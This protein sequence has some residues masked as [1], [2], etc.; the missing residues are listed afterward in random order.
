MADT[1][2]PRMIMVGSHR[3]G[4]GKTMLSVLLATALA[5]LD[6]SVM[7]VDYSLGAGASSLEHPSMAGDGKP[8]TN[9]TDK[10]AP[11]KH[12]QRPLRIL[13]APGML[14]HNDTQAELLRY[15][16]EQGIDIVI[17]DT[18]TGSGSE[19][20]AILRHATLALLVV[21]CEAN[22]FRTLL[23]LMEYIQ[24]ERSRPRRDF[25]TRAVLMEPH[26]GGFEQAQLREQL[27][28]YLAAIHLKPALPHDAALG[29]QVADGIYPSQPG[30]EMTNSLRTL[31]KSMLEIINFETANT[32]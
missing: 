9:V 30:E 4:S 27:E 18:P 2:N 8:W 23:P 28:A 3:G 22:S 10:P 13:H 7:V 11:S 31:T 12:A 15:S 25:H 21:P 5:S 24:G 17:H 1:G 14:E 29:K 16:A 19:L 32:T 20:A 6:I 26:Q